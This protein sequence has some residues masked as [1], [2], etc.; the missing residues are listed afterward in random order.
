MI[1]VVM[2][3]ERLLR[4]QPV[5]RTARCE[6]HVLDVGVPPTLQ[7]VLKAEDVA[8]D[9]CEWILDGIANAGLRGEMDDALWTSLTKETGHL[10]PVRDI[11]QDE[12]ES[13]EAA[14]LLQSRF[15]QSG[16]V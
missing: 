14:E 3:G 7:D 8:L 10:R 16:V 9:V 1:G 2:L 11:E 15:L 5:D 13:I 12:L 4:I 6:H